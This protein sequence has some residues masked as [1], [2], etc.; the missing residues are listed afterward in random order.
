MFA[1]AIRPAPL[2]IPVTEFAA[3]LEEGRI[4]QACAP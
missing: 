4:G 1:A 2:R 3:L